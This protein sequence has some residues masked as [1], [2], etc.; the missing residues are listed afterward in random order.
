MLEVETADTLQTWIPVIVQGLITIGAI[1][2]GAGFWTWKQNKDQA[3]RDAEE[4]KN[5][6]EGKIDKLSEQVT[7]VSDQMHA[8]EDKVDFMADDMQEIKK[9]I[10]ILQKANIETAKYRQ[11][12][13]NRDKEAF[14]AQ[15]AVIISLKGLLRERLLDNYYK[16]VEK[17]YYSKE[18]RETYGEMF[19]CY[20]SEPFDGNGVMHQLQPIM[21]KMP[22]T[23]EEADKKKQKIS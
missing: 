17:G 20:E 1:F 10:I 2:G 18:E 9:D 14:K 21:Q 13:D 4:K 5:G 19:K 15:E 3:K 12:R 22:W 23:K 7:G 11:L 6:A 16:C 8:I